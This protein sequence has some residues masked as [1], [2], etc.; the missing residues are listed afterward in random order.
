MQG[1]TENTPLRGTAHR[2]LKY[3]PISFTDLENEIQKHAPSTMVHLNIDSG[4]EDSSSSRNPWKPSPTVRLG[5]IVCF[6][7]SL[8]SV[9]FL[10]MGKR[11]FAP[12][13]PTEGAAW[14]AVAQP[15]SVAD[16][17]KLGLIGIDRALKTKPGP[18]FD[19]ILAKDP[20]VPL[21][22]NSWCENLFLGSTQGQ[23]NK[24]FQLPYIIDTDTHDGTR[25]GVDT[26]PANLQANDRMVMMTYDGRNGMMLGAVEEFMSQ[27]Q[28]S[29][30]LT[31]ALGRLSTVLE[32]K[33]EEYNATGTGPMMRSPIVRGA[34]YTSMIYKESTPK[35]TVDRPIL[36]N[37][38][39]DEDE[40]N[41]LICGEGEGVFSDE[42]KLVKKEL[43]VHFDTSD[44][45]WLIFVSEP[46][47]FVCSTVAEPVSTEMLPPG[48]V[49]KIHGPEGHFVLKATAPMTVGMVRIAI[50]NNCT[51]GLNPEYCG[52]LRKARDQTEFITLLRKH[53]EVYP[54]GKADIRFTFPVQSQEEEELRLNFNWEPAYMGNLAGACVHGF[55]C[56][57][58][59]VFFFWRLVFLLLVLLCC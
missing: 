29:D 57:R 32:W 42:P 8:L 13:V 7:V 5:L 2:A 41:V 21:P 37:P 38:V 12:H 18:I 31:L 40:D 6:A 9:T 10:S 53:A 26:H 15:Y 27:Q 59:R 34:P 28:V 36:T 24:V 58:L 50:G 43:K 47:S 54:T 17:M 16:P 11:T 19:A 48:V 23:E 3:D 44:F 1:A 51:T 30:D 4:S 14:S 52:P 33:S 39:V 45:T 22:T 56:V 20:T 55:C 49:S 46:T 25:Q 35:I